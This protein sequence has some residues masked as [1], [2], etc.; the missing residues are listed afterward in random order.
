[1]PT[2]K[3]YRW[4]ASPI[5]PQALHF[6]RQHLADGRRIDDLV[7]LVER[8]YP[9]LQAGQIVNLAGGVVPEWS[10]ARGTRVNAKQRV[11]EGSRDHAIT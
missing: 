5:I 6:A 2:D 8:R 10:I 11:K 1:M 3:N 7:K 4:P 9:T